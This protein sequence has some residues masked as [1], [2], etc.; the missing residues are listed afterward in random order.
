LLTQQTQ[1][2][3]H[4]FVKPK[5]PFSPVSFP[6]D[7]P[8]RWV[9]HTQKTKTPVFLTE[10]KHSKPIHSNPYPAN[11]N[12][13]FPF[14]VFFTESVDDMCFLCFVR[15][16][17]FLGMMCVC[18]LMMMHSDVCVDDADDEMGIGLAKS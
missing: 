9:T 16:L 11:P 17:C 6:A 3:T 8:L 10:T 2:K 1:K 13:F 18:V 5:A 15:F 4:Y 12:P 7:P 14:Y